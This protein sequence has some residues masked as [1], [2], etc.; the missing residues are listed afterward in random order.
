[1]INILITATNTD[2]GK[3]Y[4]TL[5]LIEAFASLGYRVGVMKPIETGV[6][7]EPLDATLLLTAAKK[8]NPDFASIMIE[9][10]CPIQFSLPAAPFV[11]KGNE[12]INFTQLKKSQEK[13]STHCDILLIE[14][15]GGLMTPVEENFIM[16][17]FL[18]FFN[19]TALLVSDD[20]L[21]CINN[22]LLSLRILPNHTLWCINKKS[23]DGSF[24]RVSL[25]YF[26]SKF[27]RVL[28][29]QD[30]LKTIVNSLLSPS[31]G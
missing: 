17:D 26:Q 9:D 10:I 20:Q 21:G 14:S 1:M 16:H 18:K 3:T 4:T 22:T 7:E 29:I 8:V 19:A 13:L 31:Q 23:S 25:P 30:D 5:K 2:I 12:K 11:A 24:E 6:K 15:A 28:T 27:D